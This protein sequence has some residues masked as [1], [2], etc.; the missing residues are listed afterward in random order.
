MDLAPMSE[1]CQQRRGT[2]MVEASDR[3]RIGGWLDLFLL[4][5]QPPIH[6]GVPDPTSE[7]LLSRT[8]SRPRVLTR[9]PN[10]LVASRGA[11]RACGARIFAPLPLPP[12]TPFLPAFLPHFGRPPLRRGGSGGFRPPSGGIGW[13]RV[14][15]GMTTLWLDLASEQIRTFWCVGHN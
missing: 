9:S 14:G 13:G 8:D 10:T 4:L 1:G 2:R 5:M 3:N 12:P 7:L 11:T 6:C 15:E